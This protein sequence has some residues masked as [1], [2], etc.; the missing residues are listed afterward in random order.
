MSRYY[1]L[2]EDY[3][4]DYGIT[5]G[6]KLPDR[7]I[8]AGEAVDGR[9]LPELR[10]EVNVPDGKPCPHFMTGGTVIASDTLV[11]ALR[12]AGVHN[13]QC[14]PARLVDPRTDREHTGYQ[15]FNVLGVA[16]LP[17]TDAGEAGC[18]ADGPGGLHMF[19]LA[20][21]PATLVVDDVVRASLVANR[22]PEGWGILLEE[23]G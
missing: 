5:A 17:G 21:S 7:S 19:R 14:F 10:F 1:E 9:L 23:L 15:L 16:R 3:L 13:F 11:A 20:D 12:G 4:H 18:A 2:S 6:P 8:L 22:P